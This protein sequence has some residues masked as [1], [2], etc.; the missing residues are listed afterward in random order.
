M[1]N[2]FKTDGYKNLADS[3]TQLGGG[4]EAVGKK[5][6]STIAG[7][8]KTGANAGKGLVDIGANAANG[9]A[10]AAGRVIGG[11]GNFAKKHEGLAAIALLALAYKPV[12]HFVKK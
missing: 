2:R 12:S 11:V 6:W 5:I 1:A 4:A 3:F 9:S 10:N 7:T 8:G